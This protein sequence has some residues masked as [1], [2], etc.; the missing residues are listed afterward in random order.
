MIFAV[1]IVCVEE[2][3]SAASS[4]NQKSLSLWYTEG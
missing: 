3:Y 2:Y 4:R 1:V